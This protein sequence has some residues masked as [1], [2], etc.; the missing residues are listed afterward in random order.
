MPLN[1]LGKKMLFRPK[2]EEGKSGHRNEGSEARKGGG[3]LRNAKF[4]F[5]GQGSL[6]MHSSP[7]AG[8]AGRNTPSGEGTTSKKRASII[9]DSGAP[10]ET[11]P[12][13]IPERVTKAAT[14][15]QVQQR[16]SAH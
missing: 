6:L 9:P 7:H 16:P 4:Q 12:S 14:R 8:D 2:R 10:S 5:L 3:I 1:S 13:K 15:S 11:G